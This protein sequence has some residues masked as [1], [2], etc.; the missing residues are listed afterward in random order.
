MPCQAVAVGVN[1][2]LRMGPS[3][4]P[5]RRRQ[6]PRDVANSGYRL[7]LAQSPVRSPHPML[8]LPGVA[9]A[10]RLRLACVL[11][12]R[13]HAVTAFAV[14]LG[15]PTPVWHWPSQCLPKITSLHSI[16]APCFARSNRLGQPWHLD[17]IL[18]R[19]HAMCLTQPTST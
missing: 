4:E 2:R 5:R 12:P 7:A 11:H 17:P 8:P 10:A 6:N 15:P 3:H 9:P 19:T 14:P 13:L 1:P 16:T 18:A